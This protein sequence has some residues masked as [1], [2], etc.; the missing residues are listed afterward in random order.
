MKKLLVPI[1]FEET[2][3][4]ALNYAVKIAQDFDYEV[5]LL[6]LLDS[7]NERSSVKN[8]MNQ[9]I[10]QFDSSTQDI[11][12]PHILQGKIDKDISKTAE[13]IEASFIIMGTHKNKRLS[14][15]F[16]SKAIKVVSE[17]KTPFIII[18][19]DGSLGN[20]NK[21]AMTIDLEKESVQIVKAA[22]ELSK[23]FGSEIILVGGDHTDPS[24]KSKVAVNVTTTRRLLAKNGIKSSVEL[25]E[26]KNFLENFIDYCASNGIDL[27]AATYYPD[28]FTVFSSK[29]VQK[30]MENEAG[31]PV[32]TLDSQAVT[33]G[34]QYSFMSI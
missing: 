20:I 34:T 8:K 7:E 27:I 4:K 19:E 30:L 6:H 17:S 16:G 22:T 33:K 28:T 2:T 29:F 5:H 26:R 21:I 32:L 11:L 9:L 10:D 3:K 15:V 31:I 14:K 24:L 23:I 18:Q 13:T 25:L 1:D 12:K